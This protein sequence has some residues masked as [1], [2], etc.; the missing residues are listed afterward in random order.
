MQLVYLRSLDGNPDGERVL[1]APKDMPFPED[2]IDYI[3]RGIAVQ[4]PDIT[5]P[6]VLPT[7]LDAGFTVPDRITMSQRPWDE[8]RSSSKM[9]FKVAIPSDAP[10]ELAGKTLTATNS[11]PFENGSVVLVDDKDQLLTSDDRP[12]NRN[13]MYR[14]QVE[15]GPVE[16]PASQF[17]TPAEF[18]RAARMLRSSGFRLVGTTM[19]G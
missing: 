9:T 7:L 13:S 1:I 11:V 14:E 15:I 8:S 5:W 6:D 2:K 4:K 12:W 17:P 16:L 3:I 10:H 18:S 19:P